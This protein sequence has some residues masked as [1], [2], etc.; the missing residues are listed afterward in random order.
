MDEKVRQSYRA[1]MFLSLFGILGEISRATGVFPFQKKQEGQTGAP[2]PAPGDILDGYRLLRLIGRGGFGEV[3]LAVAE[4]VGDFRAVK[5]IPAERGRQ[6][7]K[8]FAALGLYRRV[9]AQL[10]GA[11]LMPVEHVNWREDG[12]FYVMPLA[13]GINDAPPESEMWQ[14]CTLTAALAHWSGEGAWIGSAEVVA[15]L[16]PVLQGLQSL[17]EHGLVHRDVKPDNIL[18][19][20]GRPCLADISLLGEDKTMLTRCGTLGYAT[21]SWYVG[22]HPDM[23]G[24]AMVLFALL[25]GNEPDK[26]ARAHFLWPPQ[27]QGSLSPAEQERWMQLHAVVRRAVEEKVLERYPDFLA[28]EK[29]LKPVAT[30]R[31]IALRRPVRQ[32]W[33]WWGVGVAVATVTG[34]L[35]LAWVLGAEEMLFPGRGERLEEAR[36]VPPAIE[37]VAEENS[38]REPMVNQDASSLLAVEGYRDLL[39]QAEE[40]ARATAR[41]LEEVMSQGKIPQGHGLL[42]ALARHMYAEQMKSKARAVDWDAAPLNQIA[43]CLELAAF[44]SNEALLAQAEERAQSAEEKAF[45]QQEIEPRLR[46]WLTVLVPGVPC[47]EEYSFDPENALMREAGYGD[48]LHRAKEM[49]KANLVGSADWQSLREDAARRPRDD[50]ERWF[51]HWKIKPQLAE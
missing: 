43:A 32:D 48:L 35:A 29:A 15:M 19:L 26:M 49:A 23:F 50:F 6:L 22:G 27:G 44:R 8:E 28:F 38:L 42:V 41:C 12:L 1:S 10:R 45:F 16:G 9:S 20:G 46:H 51:Y 31:E 14:P 37:K 39:G 18:F 21:P 24:A 11:H 34:V 47:T 4:A 5:F 17:V 36:V 25:T 30:T 7:D 2:M 33:L 13:D 40:N 3:W